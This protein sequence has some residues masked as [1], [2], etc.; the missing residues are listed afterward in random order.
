L[1]QTFHL[2]P[3]RNVFFETSNIIKQEVLKLKRE[4]KQIEIWHY[5]NDSRRIEYY[6]G[7][8]PT[9]LNVF[10]INIITE[11]ISNFRFANTVLILYLTIDADA[12][13][14]DINSMNIC[15][16]YTIKQLYSSYAGASRKK[17]VNV[18]RIDNNIYAGK[19]SQ[20]SFLADTKNESLIVGD[21]E[22][23][24]AK[25]QAQFRFTKHIRQHPM[26]LD[27]SFNA[28]DNGRFDINNMADNNDFYYK[29]E[30]CNAISGQNSLNMRS[31]KYLFY[32][33][34][35]KKLYSGKYEFSVWVKGKPETSIVLFY[36]VHD[37]FTNKRTLHQV[38]SFSLPDN[39]LYLLSG[40]F[41]CRIIDENYFTVG[42][43]VSNG[44]A[45][46]DNFELHTI[47]D[48]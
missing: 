41:L 45:I 15:P 17:K 20:K 11:K 24:V 13:N 47:H 29:T 1:G 3:Y 19:I 38:A 23:V 34:F 44:E 32:F 36:N 39:N 37:I 2:D 31:N 6:T 28:P 12:S 9:L 10:S 48:K 22:H 46:L 8:K 35:D 33:F 42:V 40:S 4:G 26:F 21:I 27:E 18:Y 5:G 25:P 16:E 7:I 43:G 14:C 30:N